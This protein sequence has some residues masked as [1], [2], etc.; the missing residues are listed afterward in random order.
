M[1]KFI[2]LQKKSGA[3]TYQ[4]LLNSFRIIKKSINLIKIDVIPAKN[5]KHV[6][7]DSKFDNALIV[8][9]NNRR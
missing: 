1:L 2:E 6:I 5:L 4:F 8:L 9:T 7:K 3:T